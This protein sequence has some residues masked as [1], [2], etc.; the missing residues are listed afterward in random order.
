MRHYQ[1]FKVAII[2]MLQW[3]IIN[4]FKRSE[5]IENSSKEIENMNNQMQNLELKN[6][7][8]EI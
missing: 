7:I 1:D 4:V 6:T 8:T 3:V 2:K 5:R